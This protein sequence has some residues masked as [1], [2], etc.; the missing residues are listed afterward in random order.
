MKACINCKLW[1][2]LTSV[3]FEARSDTKRFRATCL[4]C[5]KK[6]KHISYLKNKEASKVRVASYRAQHRE[7]LLASKRENSKEYSRRQDVKLKR[8][9][10]QKLRRANDA[11][12]RLRKNISCLIRN[13]LKR[14]NSSKN[15]SSITQYL[16]YSIEEL[17]CHLES[18]FE[19]WM[20][21]QN[22]GLA[23]NNTTTWHIDHIIPQS[24]LPFKSMTDENFIKL[25]ALSNLRP[26]QAKQNCSDGATRIRHK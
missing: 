15:G 5:V 23:S 8:N 1:K 17:K 10:N 26:L 20:N 4:D 13:T 25:W 7:K 12:F 3:N 19:P 16:P 11:T 21:W 22:W 2:E 6:L 14:F 9:Y 24:C 18:E